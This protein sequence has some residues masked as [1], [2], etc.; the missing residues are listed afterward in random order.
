MK[1]A[2]ML[3]VLS[4]LTLGVMSQGLL[5]KVKKEDFTVV[6]TNRITLRA[7]STTLTELNVWRMTYGVTLTSLNLKTGEL[8]VI[9][10]TGI[11]MSR[12]NY[13]LSDQGEPY[14]TWNVGGMLLFGNKE[15]TT[16]I[17][18]TG[19]VDIGVLVAGGLGPISIGPAYFTGSKT[20]LLNLKV[21]FVF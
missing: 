6:N 20:L 4:A 16:L 18:T 13:K 17:T 7:V 12:V 21:G 10:S 8:G 15:S 3:L 1:K 5:D 14:A 2:L 9:S 11:G 19:S